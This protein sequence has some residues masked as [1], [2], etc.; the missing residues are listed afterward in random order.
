MPMTLII[1]YSKK[2][3]AKKWLL[4]DVLSTAK[5]NA[6]S[7]ASCTTLNE[8]AAAFDPHT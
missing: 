5:A 6:M 4:D 8:I 1:A 2:L 7:S 3:A